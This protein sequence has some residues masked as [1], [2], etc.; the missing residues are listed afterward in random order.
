MAPGL[1][2]ESSPRGA[3]TYTHT[4]YH[5]NLKRHTHMLVSSHAGNAGRAVSICLCRLRVSVRSPLPRSDRSEK[6]AADWRAEAKS[7]VLPPAAV[8]NNL[9]D[10]QAD[11]QRRQMRAYVRGPSPALSR[12]KRRG[13]PPSRP[14][15]GCRDLVNA[16]EVM[17]LDALNKSSRCLK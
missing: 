15:L 9:A 1:G 10:T 8:R 11:L 17:W 7:G 3:L 14:P 2:C 13:E 4:R 5:S 16:V 6:L 12:V